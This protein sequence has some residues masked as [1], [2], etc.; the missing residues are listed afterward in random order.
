MRII[1]SVLDTCLL[2]GK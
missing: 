1:V 2:I